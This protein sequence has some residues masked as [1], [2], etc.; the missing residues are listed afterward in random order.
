M[1]EHNLAKVGV[2]GSNPV[3]RS[4]E[5][6]VKRPSPEGLFLVASRDVVYERV[7]DLA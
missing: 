3:V 4:T 5:Q 7:K 2:A 6:Q 1:V